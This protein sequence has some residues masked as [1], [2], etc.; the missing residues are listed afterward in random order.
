MSPSI[1]SPFAFVPLQGR[2]PVRE[3]EPRM[4]L[5]R[6]LFVLAL[7]AA[8]LPAVAA[9][10]KPAWR[11]PNIVFI[12]ADDLGWTDLGCQGS[13]YYETANIDRLAAQ[14]MRLTSYYACQN[15]APTRAAL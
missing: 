15:C 13:K 9:E 7:V 14:G 10:R 3:E 6:C 2:F 12:L 1:P 11:P 5:S 8:A 4:K